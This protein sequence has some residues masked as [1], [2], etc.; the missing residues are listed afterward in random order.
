M[1]SDPLAKTRIKQ[2]RSCLQS[3]LSQQKD[4]SKRND[5]PKSESYLHKHGMK[6][7]SVTQRRKRTL[8]QT[9][10]VH[11]ASI[12]RSNIEGQRCRYISYTCHTMSTGC[13][14]VQARFTGRRYFFEPYAEGCHTAVV[15]AVPVHLQ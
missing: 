13:H 3:Q 7:L 11:N 15:R 10:T 8:A 14:V 9:S 12:A 2:T 1:G 5:L 6:N 4:A